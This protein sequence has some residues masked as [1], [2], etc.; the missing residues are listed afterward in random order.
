LND[1]KLPSEA[2]MQEQILPSEEPALSPPALIS[3]SKL[4]I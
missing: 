1:E 4:E 2:E 3:V